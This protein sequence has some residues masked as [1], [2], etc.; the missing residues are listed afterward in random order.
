MLAGAEMLTQKQVGQS[1]K[2]RHPERSRRMTTTRQLLSH[3]STPL[4]MTFRVFDMPLVELLGQP[5]DTFQT[6]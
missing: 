5:L 1:S 2:T 3:G 6:Q 4:T